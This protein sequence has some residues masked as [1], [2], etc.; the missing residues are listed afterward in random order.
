MGVRF[1]ETGKCRRIQ[2]AGNLTLNLI[3]DKLETE[4]S[5]RKAID[6]LLVRLQIREGTW[7]EGEESV[8]G[9]GKGTVL[10]VIQP[11]LPVSP[12]RLPSRVLRRVLYAS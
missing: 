7:G 9:V 11:R 1:V 8:G 10:G 6:H 3:S 2:F 12:P 5:K 4:A